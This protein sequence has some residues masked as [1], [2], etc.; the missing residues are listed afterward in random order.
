MVQSEPQRS[1]RCL[2]LVQHA[3]VGSTRGVPEDGRPDDSGDGLLEQLELLPDQFEAEEG[4]P[5]HVPPGSRE[6]D[7]QPASERI[8]MIGEDHGSVVVA[9]LA[10]CGVNELPATMTS[11]LRRTRSAASSESWS[12]CPSGAYRRSMNEILTFDVPE[13]PQAL[14][15]GLPEMRHP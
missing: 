3:R 14:H 5:R 13:L 15:K 9:D 10:A 11:T 8:A 6:T 7:D 12:G 1:G 4:Q 2:C